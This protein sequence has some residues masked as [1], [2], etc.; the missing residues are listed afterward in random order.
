MPGLLKLILETSFNGVFKPFLTYE[1]LVQP[2]IIINYL[3]NTDD[4]TTYLGNSEF[5]IY[6]TQQIL[7][8]SSIIY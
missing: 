5:A 4:G 3:L 8:M 6:A 2:Y 7:E 1:I